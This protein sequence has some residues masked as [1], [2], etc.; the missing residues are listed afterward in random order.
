VITLRLRSISSKVGRR[1]PPPY[2]LDPYTRHLL[3]QAL[4]PATTPERFW[5]VT[6]TLYQVVTHPA[7]STLLLQRIGHPAA[8][9]QEITSTQRLLVDTRER[10]SADNG[11]ELAY[12]LDE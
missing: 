3:S 6:E 5:H 10:S 9:D 8:Y 1:L 7:R 4:D 2:L 12:R 11:S